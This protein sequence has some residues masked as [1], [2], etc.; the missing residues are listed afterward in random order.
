M[1]SNKV[2]MK[3]KIGELFTPGVEKIKIGKYIQLNCN[4]SNK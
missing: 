3:F 4:Y 1:S 2:S